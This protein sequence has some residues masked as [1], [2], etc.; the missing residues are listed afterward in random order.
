MLQPPKHIL[1]KFYL[2]SEINMNISPTSIVYT[3]VVI[4]T[5]IELYWVLS[6][7]VMIFSSTELID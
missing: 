6:L 3:V 5:Q 4:S 1:P 2:G 7:S